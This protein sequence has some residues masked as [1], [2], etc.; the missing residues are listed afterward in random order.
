[1]GVTIYTI[2]YQRLKPTRLQEIAT[3][4]DAIVIDCRVRPQSRRAEFNKP[5]LEKLLGS[6]YLW[7]GYQLGGRSYGGQQGAITQE[8]IDWL[9]IQAA[10]QNLLLLCMEEA[11]GECH[12]HHGICDP[13]FP[14]AIHIYRDEL[15]TADS[16]RICI[17]DDVDYTLCGSLRGLLGRNQPN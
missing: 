11:P 1:M 17:K 13:H 7:R 4:L 6:R 12:R 16:L 8:G 9:R 3:V 14:D 2:G 5:A 15:L 10:H